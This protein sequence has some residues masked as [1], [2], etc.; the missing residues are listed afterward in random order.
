MIEQVYTKAFAIAPALITRQV[1]GL[2]KPSWMKP[3]LPENM[4]VHT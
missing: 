2:E 1:E 4:A 3:G